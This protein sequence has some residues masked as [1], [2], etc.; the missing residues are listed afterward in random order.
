MIFTMLHSHNAPLSFFFFSLKL[1]PSSSFLKAM[2]YL[3]M[4]Y[5]NNSP[6]KHKLYFS[7][8]IKSSFKI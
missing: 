3:V 5:V 2:C 4:S 8:F 7:S 6:P 1:K